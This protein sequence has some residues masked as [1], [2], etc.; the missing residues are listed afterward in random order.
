MAIR[1][2]VSCI[3]KRGN[4]YNAHE[5]IQKISGTDPDNTQWTI[6]EVVAIDYIKH[7]THEFYVMVNGISVE[8]IIAK[9]NNREY[10][11]TVADNYSPDNLLNLPECP[12]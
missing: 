9:H 10:L 7:K 6:V 11:K 8:I 2:Q 1:H 3:N 12:A 4:H 5:R